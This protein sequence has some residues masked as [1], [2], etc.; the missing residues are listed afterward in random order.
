MNNTDRRLR[1]CCDIRKAKKAWG[2]RRRE[3]R[4]RRDYA[5][6][7]PSPMALEKGVHVGISRAVHWSM[8]VL[9]G[10]PSHGGI[11]NAWVRQPCKHVG[12]IRGRHWRMRLR[13]IT[14]P[15]SP[16]LL[17]ELKYCA[18]CYCESGPVLVKPSRLSLGAGSVDADAR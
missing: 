18:S 13:N 7:E 17:H 16:G 11:A 5:F 4:E 12:Y 2:T 8:F 9:K 14:A 6:Y 10:Q 15:F 1:D 3:L